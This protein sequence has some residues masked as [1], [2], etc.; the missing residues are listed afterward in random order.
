M[1]LSELKKTIWVTAKKIGNN[2]EFYEGIHIVLGLVF[3]KY[4]TDTSDEKQGES[5]NKR[6]DLITAG[7]DDHEEYFTYNEFFV[8]KRAQWTF[9]LN[10]AKSAEI[11]LLVDEV[12]EA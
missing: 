2:V 11:G 10:N 7:L 5:F 3:L 12:I 9:L 6:S 1:E 4:I 8:P